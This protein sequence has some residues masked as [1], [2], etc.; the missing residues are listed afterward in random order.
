MLTKIRITISTIITK[1][2]ITI[3]ITATTPQT[4]VT[5]TT[6]RIA[7]TV[8]TSTTTKITT[9]AIFTAHGRHF[10]TEHNNKKYRPYLGPTLPFHTMHL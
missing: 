8:T 6:T 10:V 4:T 5:T 2:M 7:I 9:T 3:T 1:I